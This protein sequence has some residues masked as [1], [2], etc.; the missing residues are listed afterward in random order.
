[1]AAAAASRRCTWDPPWRVRKAF[2]E[3]LGWKLR[4]SLHQ[5][6]SGNDE[7]PRRTERQLSTWLAFPHRERV[8]LSIIPMSDVDSDIN[9]NLSLLQSTSSMARITTIESVVRTNV[10]RCLPNATS[11]KLAVINFIYGANNNHRI[12]CP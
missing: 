10:R 2:W 8:L 5:I 3:V 6:S 7:R 11:S 9:H 4:D 12:C 1:M